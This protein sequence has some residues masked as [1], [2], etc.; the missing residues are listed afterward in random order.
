MEDDKAE[1][2]R[3]TRCGL[4]AESLLSTL[5]PKP[6]TFTFS[7]QIPQ[8]DSRPS[9]TQKLADEFAAR[10]LRVTQK[11]CWSSQTVEEETF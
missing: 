5:T 6:E 1:E 10:G 8:S 11:P 9:S 7:V 3:I 4:T 2:E